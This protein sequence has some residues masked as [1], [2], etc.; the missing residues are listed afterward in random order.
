MTANHLYKATSKQ[1][2]GNTHAYITVNSCTITI[3]QWFSWLIILKSQYV[4]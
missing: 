1:V 3:F 4:V 2:N